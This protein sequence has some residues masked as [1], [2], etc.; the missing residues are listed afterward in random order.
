MSQL[1]HGQPQTRTPPA[2]VPSF[3]TPASATST[4]PP[5][6]SSSAVEE[7]E[8]DTVP[9]LEFEGESSISAHAIY[10]AKFIQS[11]II[12]DSSLDA[13]QEMTAAIKN[14]HDIMSLFRNN[15]SDKI[16]KTFP[17]AKKLPPDASARSL[18]LPPAELVLSCLRMVNDQPVVQMLW[19]TEFQSVGQFMEYFLK[20]YSPGPVTDWELIIVHAGLHWLF[21]GC[22][23]V[24]EDPEL[25]KQFLTHA[26]SSRDN[27]ETILA[28][29]P[30][31]TPL[32]RDCALAMSVAAGYC[33]MMCRPSVAWNFSVAASHTCQSLGLHSITVTSTQSADT[34]LENL[35]LLWVVYMTDKML[36]LR[37]GRSS[38]FRDSDIT[39]PYLAADVNPT[40]SL[41]P[42]LPAWIE[43]SAVNGRIYDDIYSPGALVQPQHVRE[44]RARALA[45]ELI[46]ATH[47]VDDLV[48]KYY[49]ARRSVFGEVIQK[50][51]GHLEMVQVKSML[52][53]IYRAIPAE[54]SSGT[55][56]CDECIIAARAAL[57]EHATCVSLMA[58]HDSEPEL[59]ET[60][61]NWSSVESP[62]VPFIVLFC[63]TIETADAGD[64]KYLK[65]LVTGLERAVSM[66]SYYTSCGKQLRIFTALYDIARQFIDV[67]AASI[68]GDEQNQ[69]NFELDSFLNVFGAPQ[70]DVAGSQAGTVG[71]GID[72]TR[73]VA[74]DVVGL[75]GS[76]AF[77][78]AF[79]PRGL[80]TGPAPYELGME[81]DPGGLQLGDWYQRS[82][83][84][85]RFMEN[86]PF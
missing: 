76:N 10:A 64:L 51:F 70:V 83:E 50:I 61:I 60:F 45:D 62:F 58:E 80:P 77:M 3:N 78:P 67:K 85:F 25:K 36:S 59:L 69:A 20:A 12:N 35:R 41:N 4:A 8:D 30:F 81:L 55:R 14:L 1:H 26:L 84:M 18:P 7:T 13:S 71:T 5:F 75:G 44:A 9:N 68:K 16:E 49:E 21:V 48:K 23:L 54:K 19:F 47:D 11:A 42:V 72:S 6:A 33:V 74:S 53:L 39:V 37:L 46:R 43:A 79:G 65:S 15:R 38:T 34:R 28:R 40:W 56:F 29:L 32:T 27:L 31:H 63:H 2:S 73:P 22:R 17:N 82:Q 57:E 24:V 66:Q 52:T 86:S